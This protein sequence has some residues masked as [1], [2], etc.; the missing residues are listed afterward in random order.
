MG[1]KEISQLT[2]MKKGARW[3]MRRCLDS[4]NKK[5]KWMIFEGLKLV[6]KEQN[7]LAPHNNCLI[8]LAIL[9]FLAKLW[10]WQVMMVDFVCEKNESELSEWVMIV[11]QTKRI[12]M[13]RI[14]TYTITIYYCQHCQLL[15][16]QYNILCK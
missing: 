13:A 6:T 15:Q 4:F 5:Q 3:D 10:W 2:Q 14:I 12:K 1:G 9:C 8:N 11:A 16:H 7:W